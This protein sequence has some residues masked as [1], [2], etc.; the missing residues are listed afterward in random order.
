MVRET[1]A[2]E[3]RTSRM[4]DP[5]FKSPPS[6]PLFSAT[7]AA[8]A[9]SSTIRRHDD[10]SK[11]R[12]ARVRCVIQQRH[13]PISKVA[14]RRAERLLH[15][16]RRRRRQHKGRG[17]RHHTERAMEKSICI[18]HQQRP[19]A[20]TT[21]MTEPRLALSAP[22][23]EPPLSALLY[24]SLPLPPQPSLPWI[25]PHPSQPAPPAGKSRP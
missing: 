5:T 20:S 4:I 22:T 7:S 3:T 12:L 18:N 21:M 2:D 15:S 6:P 16:K 24:H 10:R 19:Q 14:S 11:R 25:P 17:V 9:P 23:T 8:P 13:L 1:R